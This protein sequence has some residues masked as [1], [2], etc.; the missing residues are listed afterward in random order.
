[1]VPLV[2]CCKIV[3]GSTP[4]TSKKNYWNGDIPWVTPK[5]LSSLEGK[6]I[7]KTA[8]QITEEGYNSCSTTFV[9]PNSVLLSSRAPIG[10]VAINTV[11]MCTNQGF[12]SL[13]PDPDVLDANYLYYWLK[14]NKLYLQSLGNGATFKEV[15]KS[16]IAKVEI[17][18][19]SLSEQKRIAAILDKAEALRDKRKKSIA[20]L[21]ELLQ[22]VFLDMFGDPITNPKGWDIVELEELLDFITS[23]SR[24]WAKYYSDIGDT[25]IRIQNLQNG[26]LNLNEIAFVNP[27]KSAEAKRTK[28][29]S[30]DVLVS[31]T[32]DLGRVG[33][34][35]QS[36]GDA[37][38]NQHI[39]IL[40]VKEI[41]PSFLAFYLASSGGKAQFNR[42][43]RQGVKAGLNFDDL[44][45]L[46]ILIPPISLQNEF[47][48]FQD[49][50]MQNSKKL[51][52]PKVSIEMLFSSLQQRA[53]RGEL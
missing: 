49:K 41:Q 33:V 47:V 50:L 13:V 34:V 28:V 17:P 8:Q 20:K 4:K 44:R 26:Q 15:S 45:K 6:Y 25:F 10:Y 2:N 37:Y 16:I 27:P 40:R 39:A 53:F 30:G 24:G 48:Q 23:G 3:S 46:K 22:S 36:I 19:P 35:P 38:V 9:P 5:D 29:Q 1:M 7:E 18:I 12:K 42:L 11:T 31:I 21:D 14:K 32:A 51:L 43:N 52:D